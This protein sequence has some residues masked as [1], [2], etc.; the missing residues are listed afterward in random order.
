MDFNWSA[1]EEA[2]RQEIRE[3]LQAELPENWGM[4]Q[5]WDPDDD[6]Q[7]VLAHAF[8]KKLGRATG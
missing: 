1:E 7:F 8:T 2:F 6:S 4:T 3:F 5:F